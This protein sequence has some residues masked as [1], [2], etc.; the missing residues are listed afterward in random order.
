MGDT[1]ALLLVKTQ[2]LELDVLLNYT[3]STD[4]Y[5]HAA[6]LQPAEYLS[7]LR[8]G[9]MPGQQRY[10]D[11][12]SLHAVAEGLEVL[13]CEYCRGDEYRALLPCLGALERRAQSHLRLAEP[14]VAAEQ[15]LH[16]DGLH[17][18]GFYLVN[19]AQLGVGFDIVEVRLE[20]LLERI[21]RWEFKTLALH[22]AR[23]EFDKFARHLLCRCLSLRLGLLPLVGIQLVQL[24]GIHISGA[25]VP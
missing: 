11:R 19:A 14:D 23:I 13:P 1:E 2:I 24:D 10:I 4:E 25:D 18:I 8:R 20:I 6:V 7:L 15:S 16:R 22:S 12:E 5:I 21:V 17:H 9:L 3:V